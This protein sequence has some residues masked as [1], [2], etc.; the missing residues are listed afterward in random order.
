MSYKFK[1]GDKVRV[2]EWD[3]MAKQYGLDRDGDIDIEC[4]FTTGMREFCGKVLTVD[5]VCGGAVTLKG[6]GSWYFDI[7]TIKPVEETGA[8]QKIVIISDGTETLARLYEDGKVIKSAQAKCDPADEFDF[9]TGAKL[10]FDRLMLREKQ[11]KETATHLK[12]RKRNYGTV[13]TPTKY[14]DALGRPLFVGDTVDLYR[15]DKFVATSV[16]VET[17]DDGQFVMGIQVDCDEEKGETGLFTLKKN[18]SYKDVECGEV[19][20]F[21][22]YAK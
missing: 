21:I 15:N 22:E 14:V 17:K 18:R 12:C 9:E 11:K 13:G 16:V 6:A 4:C 3:E 5:S 7:D 10:A 8:T 2:R 1:V 20:S 19:V